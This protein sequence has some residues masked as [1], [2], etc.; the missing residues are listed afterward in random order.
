MEANAWAI[1]VDV[2]G[3]KVAAGFVDQQGEIHQHI[4]VAMNSHGTAAE[5]LA[6]VIS[7][8][9]ELLKLA[10]EGGN[11]T[12]RIGICAPGPL[13]PHTGVVLNPPN[14]PC[15]RNFPLATEISRRYGGS[16][17]LEND[18]KSAGLAEALWGSGRGYQNVFYT[19]IG[20]GIG[21]G[22]LFDGHIYHGRTGA[23]AEAGHMT[24]DYHGPQCGCGKKG[25]IEALA[26]GTA[27]GK[28]ARVKL[29]EK[30]ASQSVMLELAGGDLNKVSSEIV[31]QAY[32]AGD[33]LAEEIL[34]ET[35]ELLTIWLGNIVDL[36]EPDVMIIGGGVAGMLSPFFEEIRKRLPNW[37]LN[38]RCL[39]IP[40][41][42]A[43]YGTNSGIAGGAALC[44]IPQTN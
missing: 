40:L 22:I 28:K 35:V 34:L 31:G 39:E 15:W 2:G 3:T 44:T 25:C 12:R 27:I 10:P 36:L 17:K 20:T 11:L 9:D 18:A 19:C 14:V 30:S 16:V 21:A 29:S 6:A 5:G 33:P 13:D 24:I 38:S 41:V 4:R 23:A 26:S 1:G 32:A 43:R 37:S 7:A 8:I 42:P